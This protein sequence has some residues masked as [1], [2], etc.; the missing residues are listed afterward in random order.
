MPNLGPISQSCSAD[1]IAYQKILLSGFLW[2]LAKLS[3]KMYAFW[4]VVCFILL[5]KNICLAKFSVCTFLILGKINIYW[6]YA[7]QYERNKGNV[8]A[9][10]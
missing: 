9:G 10:I 3:Y 7:S 1:K 2:L 8:R 5:I 6:C 4:L